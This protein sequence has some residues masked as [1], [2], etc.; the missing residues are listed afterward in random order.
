MKD[1]H[2]IAD[3]TNKDIQELHDKIFDGV[4]ITG[5]GIIEK[6]YLC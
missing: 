6:K 5:P 4:K 1:E 3:F 2:I